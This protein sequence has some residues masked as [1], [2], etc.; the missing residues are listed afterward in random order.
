MS[1]PN[2]NALFE[3]LG[4]PDWDADILNDEEEISLQPFRLYTEMYDCI[5]ESTLGDLPWQ[6]MKVIPPDGLDPQTTP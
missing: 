5:D 3:I 4:L 6:C 1:A 2:I